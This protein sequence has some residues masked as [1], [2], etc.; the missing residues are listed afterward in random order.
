ML[1]MQTCSGRDWHAMCHVLLMAHAP[2]TRATDDDHAQRLAAVGRLAAGIAHEINT[3]VQFI[4]DNLHFLADAIADLQRAVAAQQAVLTAWRGRPGLAADVEAL[5]G[6]I[7][8]RELD[9]IAG[10]APKA[11]A[12]SLEGVQRVAVI[13]KAMKDFSHPDASQPVPADLNRAVLST[14]TLARNEY[15]YVAEA[16]TR[17]DPGMPPVPCRIGAIQQVL[18][19]LV[20]NAAHAIAAV[21]QV[22]GGRGLITVSTRRD[23][24]WVEI[25]VGDSGGGIPTEIRPRIF[26]PF[27]TTKP[28]GTGTGQGLALSRDIVQQ[29]GGT[30]AFTCPEGG[31]TVFTLR[32]PMEASHV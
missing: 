10:E 13:V 6:A 27:F 17:L 21:V 4:G 1:H 19:N 32:L 11:I 25:A 7:D 15:K 8:S 9:Y 28:V 23:G 31:G 5:N 2:P 26:E 20:V 22:H 3:P 30:I 14:L 29:H 18:L 12:Q 24:A 16:E